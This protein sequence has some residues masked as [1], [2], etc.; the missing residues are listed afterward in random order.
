[1]ALSVRI[2]NSTGA[3]TKLK[4]LQVE[5][6][7]A[8]LQRGPSLIKLPG[9]TNLTLD[10]GMSEWEISLTGVADDTHA[11][12]HATTGTANFYDLCDMRTWSTAELCR[13]YLKYATTYVD[14]RIR[15]IN[16]SKESGT[17]YWSFQ[18]A[19]AVESFTFA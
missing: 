11:A 17:E 3:Y 15:N 14:G 7:G 10:F 4:Y 19:F 13:L 16:M 5:S 8:G 12:S 6:M 2:A 18:M 9:D 1:M